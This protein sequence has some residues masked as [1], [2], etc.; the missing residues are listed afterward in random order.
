MYINLPQLK[1][2]QPGSH[3]LAATVR[4]LAIS[5]VTALHEATVL[6]MHLEKHL[7]TGLLPQG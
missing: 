7:K 3:I 1:W 5:T 4:T 2:I 6:L